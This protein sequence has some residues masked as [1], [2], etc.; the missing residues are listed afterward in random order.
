MKLPNA[1]DTFIDD[2]KLVGYCLNPQH[3][4]GQHKA[5]VFQAAL[6]IGV[7]NAGVLKAELL[8]AVKE[9]E[10]EPIQ[11]NAYG[12]KYVIDFAMTHNGRTA[13][14]H[15]VWIVRDSENSPRLVTCYVL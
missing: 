10:A 9:N 6:G 8:A 7:E 11:R 5:R 4:D 12:Q 2:E 3:S 1:E 14:I 15:S 13:T